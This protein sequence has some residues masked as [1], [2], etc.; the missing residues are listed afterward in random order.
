MKQKVVL[1]VMKKF[2]DSETGQV[3]SVGERI[4]TTKE[5]AKELLMTNFVQLLAILRI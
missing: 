4:S 3:R 5:R 2:R 1:K